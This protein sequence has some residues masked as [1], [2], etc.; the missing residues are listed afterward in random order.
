MEATKVH[1]NECWTDKFM[2]ERRAVS[3]SV[4]VARTHNN[5]STNNN[6]DNNQ[7]LLDYGAWN[8]S[9][10]EEWRDVWQSWHKK[11]KYFV[12][13]R[14][15]RNLTWP[16]ERRHR[17]TNVYETVS[18]PGSF[19]S[20]GIVNCIQN[21]RSFLND[22]W[23]RIFGSQW[24]GSD[25]ATLVDE[26][27]RDPETMRMAKR[28]L[29]EFDV[30]LIQEYFNY[31]LMQLNLMGLPYPIPEDYL[32]DHAF[33]PPKSQRQSKLAMY[34]PHGNAR[35]P[36]TGYRNLFNEQVLTELQ[37]ARKNDI[38]L[39]NYASTLA[40]QRTKYTLL[41]LKLNRLREIMKQKNITQQ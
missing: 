18:K 11:W 24:T 22:P 2:N 23:V 19:V 38:A 33:A 31:T 29:H 41:T 28:M 27:V 17:F 25:E 20:Y 16:M 37:R 9:W 13:K 34:D 39:Y 35:G 30:I 3:V 36:L 8:A 14:M 7:L 6:E 12:K 32:V 1:W 40:F 15:R 10:N 21:V 4:S 26:R 5:G